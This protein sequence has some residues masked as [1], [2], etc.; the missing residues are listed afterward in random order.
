MTVSKSENA[1]RS[2]VDG[3]ENLNF[4]SSLTPVELSDNAKIVLTKRY[5]K[6]DDE[7]NVLEGSED[8]FRRVAENIAQAERKFGGSDEKVAQ[9]AELYYNLMSSLSFVPNSPTLMNAGRELQQ[10]A[11]CFVLPVEDSME[12]IF[13]ALK[14]MA[15]IHQTGG[16]TG[17][18]FSKLR[19]KGD[20]VD[21]TKGEA[22]GPVSF[23]SVFNKA[24]EIIIQ[25]GK[26]RGAN[27]GV[28]R[29]DLISVY[30]CCNVNGFHPFGTQLRH[31]EE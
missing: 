12:G 17:F 4:G 25:G 11:A 22:S 30:F 7:G 16:G 26:R 28:L 24:T 5:L 3:Q 20:L 13:G 31:R 2:T 9:T 23:M 27:M 6:R 10:L 14:N 29:C 19:P 8:L 21:S 15:K 1:G 18:S